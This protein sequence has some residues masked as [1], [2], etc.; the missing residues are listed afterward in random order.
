M[1]IPIPTTL[2]RDVLDECKEEARFSLT[3]V[4][5]NLA[6][7][8][9]C[10]VKEFV[11]SRWETDIEEYLRS[12]N[13]IQIGASDNKDDIGKYI[14]EKIKRLGRSLVSVSGDV[15]EKAKRTI[16]DQSDGT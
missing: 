3:S 4:L 5:C 11:A 7:D 14:E 13:L 10:Y 16:T 6:K 12:E 1:P 9:K 8:A 2:V 15:K